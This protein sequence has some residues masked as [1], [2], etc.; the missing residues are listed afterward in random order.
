LLNFSATI[1][2]Y[3]RLS[4][5]NSKSAKVVPIFACEIP[6][7]KLNYKLP[8]TM[9]SICLW[10]L[11]YKPNLLQEVLIFQTK[12]WSFFAHLL[13]NHD[14]INFLKKMP[15][16]PNRFDLLTN[17]QVGKLLRRRTVRK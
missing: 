4:A 6:L 1:C 9:L 8:Y 14:R 17:D 10:R 15:G 11:A 7:E 3:Q 5:F 13:Q 2:D 12:D 16:L